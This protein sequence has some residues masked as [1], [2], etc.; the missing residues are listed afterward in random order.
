MTL[1]PSKNLSLSYNRWPFFF[2]ICNLLLSIHFQL[3][4]IILCTYLPP[5]SGP[6]HYSSTFWLTLK[7]I[8]SHHLCLVHFDHIPQ[9]LQ[10][11][12]FNSCYQFREIYVVLG[13][14]YFS[15][16][17]AQLNYWSIHIFEHFLPHIFIITLCFSVMTHVSHICFRTICR[18][19]FCILIFYIF[20]A[21]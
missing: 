20:L 2:V 19:T 14:F 4:R 18:I 5:Q 1:G 8:L 10:P 13:W 15:E 21:V 3:L 17:I 6:S 9:P 7:N 16:P 12:P 11:P